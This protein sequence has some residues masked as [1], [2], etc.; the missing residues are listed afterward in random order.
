MYRK[1]KTILKLE[2]VLFALSLF[3]F[4]FSICIESLKTP[5]FVTNVF[6][7]TNPLYANLLVVNYDWF[8]DVR[9]ETRYVIAYFDV[10]YD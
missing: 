4:E 2:Q 3:F 10:S 7:P 8:V 1:T 5:E 9:L 6:N